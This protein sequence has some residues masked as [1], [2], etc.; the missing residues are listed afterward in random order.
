MKMLA[1]FAAINIYAHS[2]Y[3][4]QRRFN[5]LGYLWFSGRHRRACWSRSEE[6][7]MPV[8]GRRL[9]EALRR[10]GS[11][12]HLLY[13]CWIQRHRRAAL[14]AGRPAWSTVLHRLTRNL[15][16]IRCRLV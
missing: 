14:T 2:K 4:P 8:I 6:S 1:I 5:V 13:A 10:P 15:A 7:G 11:C 9:S 12:L 3:R 16:W